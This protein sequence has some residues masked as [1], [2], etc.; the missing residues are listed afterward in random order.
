MSGEV[1]NFDGGETC[2]IGG[3]FSP[4]LKVSQEKWD[5]MEAA[6]R[7]VKGS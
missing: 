1:I 3:E 7:K 6:I 5:E 2:L 4:L